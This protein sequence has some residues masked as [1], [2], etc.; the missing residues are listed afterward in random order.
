MSGDLTYGLP[1]AARHIGPSADE[2]RRMLDSIRLFGEH[3]IPKF[4][5]AAPVT[6][7]AALV[8]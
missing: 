7:E 8:G 1:F 5:D 3:V 4:S 2:Q 6:G